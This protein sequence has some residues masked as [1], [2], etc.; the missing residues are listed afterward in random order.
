MSFNT[1]PDRQRRRKETADDII[2][3]VR[4][5]IQE[6]LAD[7][8]ESFGPEDLESIEETILTHTRLIMDAL[9]FNEM[10]SECALLSHLADA[11]LETIRLMRDLHP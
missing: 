5:A 1:P 7:A 11:R 2:Q 3:Q 6:E 9:S 10:Q 4:E 8:P